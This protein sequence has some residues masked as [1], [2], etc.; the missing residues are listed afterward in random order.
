MGVEFAQGASGAPVCRWKTYPDYKDS[1]VEWLGEIPAHWNLVR[2]KFSTKINMGQSPAS[3]ECNLDG[4]GLPF[5]QGNAEFGKSNPIPKIFC[6]TARKL[7]QPEDFLLS[8]RAPVGALNVADQEY[9]IGRGLCAITPHTT[10]NHHYAWYL[11]EVIRIELNMVATGS[12]YEAVSVDQ[13]GNIHCILPQN[14]EQRAI[15]SFLDRK[16]SRIDTLISKKQRLITL[17]HEKRAAL[18][19]HTVTKGL[20]PD[21]PMKDSGVEWLGEIPVHWVSVAIKHLLEVKDG[22]HDTPQ[23]VS[24]SDNTFQLITSKDIKDGQ[25]VFEE[26]K[27]ISQDDYE[28][29]IKRSNVMTNDV[30]MPMIGTIGNPVVIGD[31]NLFAIKN[32][33]LFKT[34]IGNLNSRYLCYFLISNACQTQFKLLYRGGVQDFVSLSVLRNLIVFQ[35][36]N[37]EDNLIAN[38]LDNKTSKIDALI[39]KIQEAIEKLQEYRTALISAAVTG[40]IDVR[41]ENRN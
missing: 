28:T 22:T 38:Y 23:F 3:E 27:H 21:V 10:L 9:G 32:V 34:C 13:I 1:G 6:S 2:L 36:A 8:V 20:D 41:N 24:P 26:A 17:L 5:L 39:S 29:I 40:K 33:A 25:L 14:P 19:S 18:I 30:I 15:A 7:A 16:T 4:V 31:Y 37:G 12:T 11:L 35:M